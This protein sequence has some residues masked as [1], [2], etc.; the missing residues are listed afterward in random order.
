MFL[1]DQ[2]LGACLSRLYSGCSVRPSYPQ[3]TNDACLVHKNCDG[4]DP[5]DQVDVMNFQALLGDTNN[6]I[7][8]H[9]HSPSHQTIVLSS[10][11][12]SNSEEDD[13]LQRKYL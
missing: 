9:K 8:D 6:R 10:I 2:Y 1:D 5:K 3:A 12:Q 4:S 7:Y 13:F 11:P